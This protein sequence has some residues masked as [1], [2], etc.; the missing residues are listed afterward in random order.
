VGAA[1]DRKPRTIVL[2]PDVV[3][4]RDVLRKVR[5]ADGAEHVEVRDASGREGE[6][7]GIGPHRVRRQSAERRARRIGL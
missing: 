4:H 5:D 2:D 7:V 1:G 3:D 6:V